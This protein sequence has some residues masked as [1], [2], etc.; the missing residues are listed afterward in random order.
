[1]EKK[2]EVCGHLGK[3]V[4]YQERPYK[5]GNFC[6]DQLACLTRFKQTRKEKTNARIQTTNY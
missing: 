1:M 2:C 3:D 4:E 6:K 5:S